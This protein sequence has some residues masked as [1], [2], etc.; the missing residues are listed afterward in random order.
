MLYNIQIFKSI[1]RICNWISHSKKK[2]SLNRVALNLCI[3]IINMWSFQGEA[4]FFLA[5]FKTH[6]EGASYGNDH[7][8]K[9]CWFQPLQMLFF[10]HSC[11]CPR[12]PMAHRKVDQ[13]AGVLTPTHP[14]HRQKQ[15]EH[16]MITSLRIPPCRCQWLL[17]Y[18]KESFQEM[19]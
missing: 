14:W 18:E 19:I 10:V 12:L 11:K 13:T 5:Y 3:M 17:C 6:P 2:G 8:G 4:M 1:I 7:N 9:K 16:A 15:G